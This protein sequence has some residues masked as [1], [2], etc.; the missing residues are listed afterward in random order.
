MSQSPAEKVIGGHAPGAQV[1]DHHAGPGGV[2]RVDR[3]RLAFEHEMTLGHFG[4]PH[5][6]GQKAK[7]E[8]FA[9]GNARG[10]IGSISGRKVALISYNGWDKLETLIET[11]R[12]AEAEESTVLYVYRK[13]TAK[14][15]PMELM[16]TVMLHRT[17]DTPWTKEELNPIK[18]IRIMD[19]TPTKSVLGAELTLAKWEELFGRFQGHR[20]IQVLLTGRSPNP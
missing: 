1:V 20:R 13:R 18:N 5:M 3:C 6:N 8:N 12:N 2:I 7:V 10:L 14:N 9:D 4:L 15:P 19:V 16:I 11:G 17:D